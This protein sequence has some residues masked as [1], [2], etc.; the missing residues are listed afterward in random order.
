M[1][2]RNF[3]IVFCTFL[4]WAIVIVGF[5]WLH[6]DNR[7]TSK[8]DFALYKIAWYSQIYYLHFNSWP[9]TFEDFKKDDWIREFEVYRYLPND[10]WGIPYEYKPYDEKLGYGAV[11]SKSRKTESRFNDKEIYFIIDSRRAEWK[12]IIN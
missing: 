8:A 12:D 3:I 6:L 11:I 1:K 9:K 5:V 10:P 2:R 7:K 4:F